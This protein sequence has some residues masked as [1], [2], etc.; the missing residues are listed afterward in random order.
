MSASSGGG[1]G[2]GRGTSIE[3]GLDRTVIGMG[4]GRGRQITTPPPSAPSVPS[5]TVP[6]EV[7]EIVRA[8]QAEMKGVIKMCAL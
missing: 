1:R 3:K 6:P 8:E 4:R 5:S 7:E 2:R